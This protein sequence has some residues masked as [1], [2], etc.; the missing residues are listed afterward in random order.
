[1]LPSLVLQACT[2]KVATTLAPPV[3]MWLM[4]MAHAC[5]AAADDALADLN[6]AMETTEQL[7]MPT[8]PQQAAAPTVDQLW[9]P[10]NIR[11]LPQLHERLELTVVSNTTPPKVVWSEMLCPIAMALR[12]QSGHHN[13]GECIIQRKESVVRHVLGLS[14]VI[15]L[16]VPRLV[17]MAHTKTFT[18]TQDPITWGAVEEMEAAGKLVIWPKIVVLT[19]TVA[20]TKQAYRCSI[21]LALLVSLM[22]SRLALWA[23]MKADPYCLFAEPSRSC[24]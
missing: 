17:C 8:H 1:M 18:V 24:C 11:T 14:E 12:A 3:R 4:H 20:L 21:L 10:T 9:K 23:S 13:R 2:S 19:N 15:E 22:L 16:R 7:P 6:M 5:M